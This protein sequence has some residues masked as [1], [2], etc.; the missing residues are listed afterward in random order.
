MSQKLYTIHGCDVTIELSKDDV[1]SILTRSL[2]AGSNKVQKCYYELIGPGGGSP[3]F[4]TDDIYVAHS[5]AMRW[6]LNIRKVEF[7]IIYKEEE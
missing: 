1:S 3:V 4:I 7:D 6:C 5:C 2:L